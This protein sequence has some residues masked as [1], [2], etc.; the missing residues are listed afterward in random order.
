MFIFPA[1]GA[2]IPSRREEPPTPPDGTPTLID[3][4]PSLMG[5]EASTE[6]LVALS[7]IT[8]YIRIHL[9]ATNVDCCVINKCVS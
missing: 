5:D 3:V 9:M 8:S 7:G 2:G 6:H 4:L 1:L